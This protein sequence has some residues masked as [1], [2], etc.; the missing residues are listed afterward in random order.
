MV[1]GSADIGLQPMEPPDIIEVLHRQF[2]AGH[3]DSVELDNP[4]SGAVVPSWCR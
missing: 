1:R 4:S 2:P 3:I